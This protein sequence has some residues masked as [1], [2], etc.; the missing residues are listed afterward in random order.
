MN[1]LDKMRGSG[2]KPAAPK[3]LHIIWSWLG[4]SVGIGLVALV[5]VSAGEPLLMAPLGASAV[6]A[7]GIP[8]SPLAQPRNI[9]GGHIVTA[10]VGLV[11]LALFGSGWWV[12]GLAV[13]T[14]IAGMQLTGT[15]HPPAG[16][17]PLIVIATAASW[18]YILLP[19]ASSAVLLTLVALL[20]NNLSPTRRYPLY[21]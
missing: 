14:S 12:M 16:A 5:A 7:F 9:I 13:A 20:V 18:D 19:V 10:L 15:V 2:N 21:W 6:L 8:E 1:Y 11:F 3:A 4:A 17:N